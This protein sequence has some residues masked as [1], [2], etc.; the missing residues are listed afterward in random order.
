[1]KD[2]LL[3]SPDCIPVA[4]ATR[5]I[6]YDLGRKKYYILPNDFISITKEKIIDFDSLLE[7][8]PTEEEHQTLNS[9]KDFLLQKELAFHCPENLIGNIPDLHLEYD[10]PGSITNAIIDFEK[11]SPYNIAEFIQAASNI[12]ARHFLIRSYNS[13]I[14]ENDLL[15]I[16]SIFKNSA[17][18][19]FEI[20][21]KYNESIYQFAKTSI[22]AQP[23]CKSIVL[24][25]APSVEYIPSKKNTAM[26]IFVTT[27]QKITEPND[28][29]NNSL[30]YM[31]VNIELFLEAKKF[32]TYY[33]KKVAIDSNGFIKNCTS[34]T[35]HYGQFSSEKLLSIVS[36]TAF[37]KFWYIKKD[38]TE[39]CKD[40]EFRYMCVD[41]REPIQ[42]KNGK[43]FYKEPCQYNPYSTK[44]S[45]E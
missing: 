30:H 12:G 35:E 13:L 7:K 20:I 34:H 4:G 41:S 42:G 28:C 18:R 26:G 33:Y 22:H 9:F 10:S 8:Y 29:K 40:C 17:I 15:E 23:R 6:I 14:S 19:S 2:I 16:Y 44:W 39:V 31:N 1:M 45:N 25:S 24:H 5:G 32:H 21:V 43:W 37:Q 38:D 3:R 36:S 11:D 27:V